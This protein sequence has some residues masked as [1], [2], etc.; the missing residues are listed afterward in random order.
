M[1]GGSRFISTCK[2]FRYWCKNYDNR[3]V[4]PCK[5]RCDKHNSCKCN[6]TFRAQY[7]KITDN[8][9][10]LD[11]NSN[12]I[13]AVDKIR[14]VEH[15]HDVSTDA[16]LTALGKLIHT[17]YYSNDKQVLDG[18]II[19]SIMTDA[20]VKGKLEEL[21]VN[22]NLGIIFNNMQHLV[23]Y[24]KL[25]HG[26]S[27]AGITTITSTTN[28]STD[29]TTKLLTSESSTT[30]ISS[31]ST[32]PVNKF[33]IMK[34]L[35]EE[36]IKDCFGYTHSSPTFFH[37]FYDDVNDPQFATGDHLEVC[38]GPKTGN[39]QTIFYLT[40]DMKLWLFAC[41][42]RNDITCY[43]DTAYGF[44]REGLKLTTLL[45][46]HRQ[47]DLVVPVGVMWHHGMDAATYSYFFDHINNVSAGGFA[48][49]AI[50][51]DFCVAIKSAIK[52]HYTKANHY[53]CTFHMMNAI[54]RRCLREGLGSYWRDLSITLAQAVAA[55]CE[56]DK[57]YYVDKFFRT[58]II[59]CHQCGTVAK[60]KAW[61]AFFTY[62]YC[63]WI[64]NP[65]NADISKSWA[66]CYRI[67]DHLHPIVSGK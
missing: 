50:V 52:K 8:Y 4:E 51:S 19:R 40:P 14:V 48:P 11:S 62:V 38:R 63:N 57:N 31:S 23:A 44:G 47:Y 45:A 29:A 22:G 56:A 26:I 24:P 58:C 18:T 35:D 13:A 66:L 12:K 21:Y 30:S 39:K 53:G 41:S 25:N 46:H 49:N 34:Q 54:Y 20:F 65:T 15:R 10:V 59:H 1:N 6:A 61:A 16:I 64:S 55:L 60:Q 37:D 3:Y 9:Y 5:F 7:N 43:I 36:Q 33:N 42:N 2:G 67:N 17:F 32:S 27:S 28:S